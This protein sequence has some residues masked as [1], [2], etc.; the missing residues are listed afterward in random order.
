[1]KILVISNSLPP[2]GGSEG[3]AWELAKSYSSHSK[4]AILVFSKDRSQYLREGVKIYTL[5]TVKIL[6]CIIT[7]SAVKR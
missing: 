4:S 6:F 1:M 7:H 3:V 2:S 5:P